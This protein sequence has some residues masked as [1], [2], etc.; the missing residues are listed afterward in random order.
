MAADNTIEAFINM[1]RPMIHKK[2]EACLK[3]VV[4][5]IRKLSRE[6]EYSRSRELKFFKLNSRFTQEINLAQ[7][8]VLLKTGELC[9][10]LKELMDVAYSPPYSSPNQPH[11]EMSGWVMLDDA[12]LSSEEEEHSDDFA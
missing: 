2:T 10:A 8:D 6:L 5:E 9:A 7:K 11:S 1:E 4:D 12:S 3:L